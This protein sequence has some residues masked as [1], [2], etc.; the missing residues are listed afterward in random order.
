MFYKRKVAEIGSARIPARSDLLP[1]RWWV[2]ISNTDHGIF[3]LFPY[4]YWGECEI[5]CFWLQSILILSPST[6]RLRTSKYTQVNG[7]ELNVSSFFIIIFSKIENDSQRHIVWN[8]F[9]RNPILLYSD[10]PRLNILQ[11][12]PLHLIILSS[13]YLQTRKEMTIKFS[14]GWSP[15]LYQLNYLQRIHWRML[16]SSIMCCTSKWKD[17]KKWNYHS[18]WAQFHL[19][20]IDRKMLMNI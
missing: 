12:N 5:P 17:T 14:N 20:K 9:M 16:S 3:S 13:R 11:I 1:V 4:Q 18:S 10:K 7:G 15:F 6:L 19:T 8:L 2:Y